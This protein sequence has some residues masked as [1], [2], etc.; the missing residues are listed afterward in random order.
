MK[1]NNYELILLTYGDFDYQ[2][3]KVNKSGIKDYF[4]KIIITSKHKALLNLDYEHSVFIDDNK[5]QLEGLL[6]TG[7]KVIRI[8]RSGNKH[9]LDEIKGVIEFNDFKELIN[10]MTNEKNNLFNC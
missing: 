3:E 7:A 10:F 1:S 9:Y 2:N 4:D 6:K 8:K 5:V